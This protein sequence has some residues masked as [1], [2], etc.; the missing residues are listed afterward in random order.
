MVAF[1]PAQVY[2]NGVPGDTF[3]VQASTNLP[4]WFPILITT[5]F[6]GSVYFTDPNSTASPSRV[7]RA[8]A[9]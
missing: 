4:D 1:P 9:R 6:A 8:V 2:L 7:Y 3:E 5:N